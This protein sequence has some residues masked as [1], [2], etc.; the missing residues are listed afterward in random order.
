MVI[1]FSPL[2]RVGKIDDDVFATRSRERQF[3][4][5]VPLTFFSRGES[6][7]KAYS[8]AFASPSSLCSLAPAS[9]SEMC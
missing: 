3:F 9:L 5:F 1:I 2:D 7:K 4:H 6:W 8:S